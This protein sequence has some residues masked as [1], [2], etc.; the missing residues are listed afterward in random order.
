MADDTT[1]A[2]EGVPAAAS[3]APP[4]GPAPVSVGIAGRAQPEAPTA[5]VAP[6]GPIDDA[7]RGLAKPRR[8]PSSSI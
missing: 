4:S 2:G 6:S 5:R 8:S 1:T 3:T 7:E